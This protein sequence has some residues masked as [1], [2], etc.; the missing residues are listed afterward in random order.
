MKILLLSLLLL[1]L[2]SALTTAVAKRISWID[3]YVKGYKAGKR[4][5]K[6]NA[7]QCENMLKTARGFVK[8]KLSYDPAYFRIGYPNG[9]VP[10]GK[11]V[12]TDVVVR[13]ARVAGLDLQQLVHEDMKKAKAYYPPLW[14][15]TKPDPNID[16]RRVPNLLAWFERNG[17]RLTLSKEPADYS[18]CDVVAWELD[19]GVTHIGLVTDK[20]SDEGVPLVIHHFGGRL[21]A[22]ENVLL[23][24]RMIGHFGI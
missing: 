9:D 7:K 20:K 1:L 6:L 18:P 13:A 24:W 8:S 5:G 23:H 17:N 16:H 12:C 15:L 19:G 14:N 21:P 22:E 10:A 11:G 3:S 2:P 4:E